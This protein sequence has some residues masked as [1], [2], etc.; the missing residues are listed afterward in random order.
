PYITSASESRGAVVALGGH[1]KLPGLA[2]VAALAAVAVMML[3]DADAA[4]MGGGRSLGTQRQSI[5]PP[6]STSP[7]ASTN[8]N[9]ASQPALPAQ[10]GATLPARPATAPAAAPS[11]MSRWLG[12][13]AGLAAG[14][15]LAA[16][17][18]H[19][20]LGEGVATF[21]MLAL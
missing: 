1:M 17:L 11:G 12:P 14:I 6:R 3:N 19:F 5:S 18:S 20:G 16:L 13:I 15:G 2:W 21:L 8:P 4:R 10:P 9:A 7:S